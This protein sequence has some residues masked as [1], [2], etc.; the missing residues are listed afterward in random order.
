MA[1]DLASLERMGAG[2]ISGTAFDPTQGK[3]GFGQTRKG[4]GDT[5][6][7]KSDEAATQLAGKGEELRAATVEIQRLQKSIADAAAKI[8]ADDTSKAAAQRAKNFADGLKIQEDAF[9]ALIKKTHES[10]EATA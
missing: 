5:I 6:S 10:N 3:Y 2:S 4:L 1:S 8:S 7:G 9:D